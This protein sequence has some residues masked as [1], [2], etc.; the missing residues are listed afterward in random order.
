MT[1]R[2]KK[3]ETFLKEIPSNG[4]CMIMT[5]IQ[6][7][8]LKIV[9]L[10]EPMIKI[11]SLTLAMALPLVT[12]DLY[13]AEPT[14]LGLPN[15]VPSEGFLTFEGGVALTHDTI[16]HDSEGSTKFSFDTGLRFDLKGGA[17]FSSGW[18]F[19][20]D[21][22][23]IYAP[24]KGNPLS[25]D[26]GNLELYEI[27]MMVDILYTFPHWGRLRGYIGG[28]IGGV[29][30]IFTGN[31][32]SL[33]GF[34]SDLTFGYQGIA[35]IKYALSARCDIGVSYKFLGTTGHDLGSGVSMDGTLTH[36]FMAA[37]T[38]KF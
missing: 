4:E 7:R 25:T 6:I 35:G 17:I 37:L 19:D 27:P 11:I 3:S 28:G 31:G 15:Q 34:T 30:G 9:N 24:L 2:A 32:T 22:G 23:V 21:L 38:I 1:T 18:G 14:G 5:R 33:F 29:Y 12:A 36:S 13:A 16:I 26:V 20:L 8:F 10:S